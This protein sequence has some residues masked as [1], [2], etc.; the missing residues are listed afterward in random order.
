[1]KS[2][3]VAGVNRI[4]PEIGKH[5]GLTLCTKFHKLFVAGRKATSPQYS[6]QGK[7]QM[8]PIKSYMRYLLDA[9]LFNL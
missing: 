7:S 8:I 5:E 4:P 6:N 9:G 2:G 1:M 3:K